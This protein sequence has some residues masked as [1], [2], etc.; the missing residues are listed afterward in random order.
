MDAEDAGLG[1]RQAFLATLPF[2][3]LGVA[4]VVLLLNYGL[5]PLWG[6]LILPPILM[7]SVL[8]WI[9]FRGGLARDRVGEPGES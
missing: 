5:D 1:R 3:A 9:A 4:D 8:T 7:M 6:F 2:V